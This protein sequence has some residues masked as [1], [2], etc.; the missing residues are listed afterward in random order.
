MIR[1]FHRDKTRLQ[2]PTKNVSSFENIMLAVYKPK[3]QRVHALVISMGCSI[4][5]MNFCLCCV[6]YMFNKPT[7]QLT[8][9]V[10]SKVA[11]HSGNYYYRRHLSDIDCLKAHTACLV[12]FISTVNGN[13]KKEKEALKDWR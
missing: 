8:S 6:P 10:E 7:S 5:G 13:R 9:F 11:S 1:M 3:Q 2:M 12:C 4:I